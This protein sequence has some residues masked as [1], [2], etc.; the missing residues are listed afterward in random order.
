MLKVANR[1]LENMG[2]AVGTEIEVYYTRGL[3]TVRK[4]KEHEKRNNSLSVPVSAQAAFSG[5]GAQDSVQ[6]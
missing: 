2:F 1:Q 6:H 3:I 4:I 5:R